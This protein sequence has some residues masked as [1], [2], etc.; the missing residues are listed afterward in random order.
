MAHNDKYCYLTK[1]E[2]SKRCFNNIYVFFKNKRKERDIM[3]SLACVCENFSLMLL[4]RFS[5]VIKWGV[6]IHF[7]AVSA[8][9][10]LVLI[11]NT[12]ETTRRQ[13]ILM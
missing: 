6:V 13:T 8:D 5:F 9:E 2:D 12:V 4:A 3:Y 1:R 11:L 10:D 7:R